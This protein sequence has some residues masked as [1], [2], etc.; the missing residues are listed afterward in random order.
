MKNSLLKTSAVF[1]NKFAGKLLLPY[2]FTKGITNNI[3][4]RFTFVS[5][6]VSETRYSLDTFYI[7]LCIPNERF[8]AMKSLW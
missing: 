2:R 3:V 6:A 5:T 7:P 1:E 4:N 8:I